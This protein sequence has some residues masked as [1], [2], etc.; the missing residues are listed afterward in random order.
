MSRIAEKREEIKKY[1]QEL[2][3]IIPSSF[4]EYSTGIMARAACERYVE[5][6]VEASTDL[7]FFLI[8]Q[9]KLKKPDDDAD[10]FNILCS[11]KVITENL[12][13]K[14]K[15]VKGMK[16]IIAH[17]YGRIDD[18]VVYEAIAEHL[19][20]DINEFLGRVEKNEKGGKG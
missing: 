4:E 2:E 10:A 15:A 8:K 18:S 7:A 16:N 19:S 14:L 1:L 5:K 9:K 11:N 3:A 13:R 6:I 17:Q 20:K 12:S